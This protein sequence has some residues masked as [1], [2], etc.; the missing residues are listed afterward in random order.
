MSSI[1]C[2]IYKSKCMYMQHFH[3]I[4]NSAERSSLTNF[5][6]VLFII[7]Y[8]LSITAVCQQKVKTN[9]TNA[10]ILTLSN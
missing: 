9:F 6:F 10:Q 8:A 1:V 3:W 4:M 7:I 5:E 2:G